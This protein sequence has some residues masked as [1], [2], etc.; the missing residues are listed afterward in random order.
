MEGEEREARAGEALEGEV[1]EELP[2]PATRFFALTVV[3]GTEERV[4]LILAERARAAGLSVKSII[5]PPGLKGYVIVEVKK[6][7]DLYHLIRG[8]RH[9]KRRRPLPVKPEEIVAIVKPKVEIPELKPG[10]IVEI[11][12]G[13]FKGLTGRVVE[14]NKSKRQVEV[15]LLELEFKNVVTIPLEHVRP[16]REEGAS[17]Q[18]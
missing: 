12:A 16:V 15:S 11:V 18:A 13:P 8:I 3:G 4:A 17:S 6:V 1:G 2:R 7:A 5:V 10:D 14:V 9:I